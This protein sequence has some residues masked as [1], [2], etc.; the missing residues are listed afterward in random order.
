MEFALVVPILLML[1]LGIIQYGII[2]MT[3][4]SLTNLSREGARYAAT[5]PSL[6]APIDA[7]IEA[8]LP[9]NIQWSDIYPKNILILPKQGDASR[10]LGNASPG[11]ISVSITYDMRKKLFI[12]STFFNFHIFN[13]TYTTTT[14]MMIE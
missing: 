13:T 1:T 7:R 12:P 2:F 5:A 11:L 4:L 8:L 9:S 10:V 14:Y 6:D 3:M